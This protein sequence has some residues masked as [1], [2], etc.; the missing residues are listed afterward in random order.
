MSFSRQIYLEVDG[1]KDLSLLMTYK[2]G[3]GEPDLFEIEVFRSKDSVGKARWIVDGEH[4]ALNFDSA[5]V[6]QSKTTACITNCL[7][8]A[9]GK[10]LIECLWTAN[11]DPQK[12]RE[13]IK[14]K[15]IGVLL[16]A[17]GCVAECF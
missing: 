17:A 4:R 9:V 7:G 3:E 6:M 16:D 2:N 1:G 11:G 8:I 12:I 10:G 14:E 13:C 15:A 5:S